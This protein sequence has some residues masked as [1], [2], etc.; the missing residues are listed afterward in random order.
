[1]TQPYYQDD[2]ITLW[3]GDALSVLRGLPDDGGV[4]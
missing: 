4:A 1:M 2:A 3:Q